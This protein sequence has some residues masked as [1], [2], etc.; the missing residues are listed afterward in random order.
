MPRGPAAARVLALALL[1]APACGEP[2][3]AGSTTTGRDEAYEPLEYQCEADEASALYEQRIAPLLTAERPSSCNSCHLAGID[4]E[5]YVQPTPCQTMACLVERDL[6]DLDDPG[7]ST[8]LQW[9]DRGQ[10]TSGL[11]TKQIIDE[12]Y[13]GFRAWIEQEAACGP[14]GEFEDP[15]GDAAS[16]PAT[17]AP[18]E[19][20]EPDEPWQD[21]GDCSPPTLEAMFRHRVHRWRDRCYPCH[22][23][24]KDAEG[25]D[26][27]IE[28]ECTLSSLR[29]MNT[30]LR[31]GYVDL[32]HPERSLLLLKPLAEAAGGLEHGGHDKFETTADEAYQD[33]ASWIERL[34]QCTP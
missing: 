21:P 20:D 30:V 19:P 31:E 33:Y 26:W 27:I 15:C 17:C 3:G 23:D 25:P 34:A 11:I 18:D 13:V 22:Y 12:E 9:I 16:E 24:S 10:P 5:L 14:C 1:A 7:A 29:T 32:A 8:V 2:P 6:V 4:L 28:D